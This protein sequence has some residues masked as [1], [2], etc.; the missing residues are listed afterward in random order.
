MKNAAQ[1]LMLPLFVLMLLGAFHMVAEYNKSALPSTVP[2]VVE[3][4]KL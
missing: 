2:E 1:M 3:Y 4:D